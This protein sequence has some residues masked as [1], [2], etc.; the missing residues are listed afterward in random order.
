MVGIAFCPK[1]SLRL[2]GEL[3]HGPPCCCHLKSSDSKLRLIAVQ[4]SS[5]LGMRDTVLS[6]LERQDKGEDLLEEIKHLR[7]PDRM[8]M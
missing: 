7:I 6:L 2:P 1:C 8:G 4:V 5:Q 3:W